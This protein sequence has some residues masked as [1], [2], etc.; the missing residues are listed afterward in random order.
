MVEHGQGRCRCDIPDLQVKTHASRTRERLGMI[1]D[2]LRPPNAR[3]GDDSPPY[4][5]PGRALGTA[6][7]TV[8]PGRT[9]PRAAAS[10]NG[11][12]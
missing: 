11:A 2:V 6:G 5:A 4:L 12:K 8:S 9:E 3:A 10:A 1:P 7:V